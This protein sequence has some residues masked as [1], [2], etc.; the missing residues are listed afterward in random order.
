MAFAFEK[1]IV[2]QRSVDFADQVSTATEAFPRGYGFLADQLNRA[3]LSIAANLAE[4]NGRFTKP[5]RRNFFGIARGSV[6]ECVPLLEL[7]RR[8]S[9]ITPERH[10]K[11]KNDLE[12]I[13][14]ML[15]GLINGLEKRSA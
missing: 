8:R 6:Q 14:K 10:M 13:A 9:L 7:A 11:M 4:G 5:D 3:S 12:E 2:Y 15:S 1:L